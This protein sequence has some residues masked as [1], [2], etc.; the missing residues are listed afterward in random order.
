M[1]NAMLEETL[2]VGTA[3][4]AE[5]PGWPAAGKTGTSQD[6]RDAWFVG[7]TGALV[8]VVWL[9]N[10]DN[11]PTK[12]ASGSNLPV[13]IWSRFMQKALA[14]QQPVGLPGTQLWAARNGPTTQSITPQLSAERREE[15][16]AGD[17]G[18]VQS[19]FE[20]LFGG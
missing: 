4:K 11:S 1:M 15:P 7:Y 16:R 10:D 2:R 3:K 19:F 18:Q 14:S 6:F 8:S 17:R 13:E 9:G 20:R 5:L 12:K